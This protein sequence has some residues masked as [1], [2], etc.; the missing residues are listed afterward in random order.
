M[1]CEQHGSLVQSI[2]AI[3]EDVKQVKDALLGDF[4]TM[5]LM[6]RVRNNEKEVQKF[7]N[8]KAALWKILASAFVGGGAVTGVIKLVMELRQ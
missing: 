7:A 1:T 6:S 5:G 8:V 4:N 2:N 3:H